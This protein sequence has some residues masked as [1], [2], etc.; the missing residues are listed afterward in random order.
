MNK[1]KLIILREYLTRIKKKSFIVMT[2]L[3]PVLFAAMMVVPAWLASMEDTDM[4]NIAVVDS[5]GIF[6]NKI[7]DTD[8][9]KFEYLE[10]KSI[11]EIHKDFSKS[12]YYAVLQ[13]LPS[14]TY[15][16][17]AVHLFSDKQTSFSVKSHIASAMEKE[18][19]NRKLRAHGIDEEILNSIKSD[20]SIRTIQWT[21]DGIK[22]SSTEV[23]MIVGYASGFLIYFFIFLFGAQVMRGVIEEKTNRIVEI[24]VSSAK[25]FQLMMGKIVGIAMV[26]LT[27]FLL[28]ILLTTA[29]ITGAKAV[30]FPD[31]GTK[32]A[33]EV[34]AQDLF[35]QQNLAQV[36]QIQPQELDKVA[37]IFN[38]V[39]SI[40]FGVIFGSFIFYF[41]GGYLLYGSLFAAIGSAVDNE[42]DT[43]QFMLPITIP[44]ILGI[45]VMMNAIQTPDSPV[46]F[47]FSIIPLTSPIVMMVRIP[48]GVPYW[49]IALSM[50]L[51]VITF[52]G[53]VWLA[54]KIYRTGILMYGKKVNYKEIWKW[55][56]YKS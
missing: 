30:F 3:G 13:I 22:E 39:K 16:P 2:I 19:K 31:L 35:Q 8:Y 14:I 25:P 24:I 11:N 26:G 52:L 27:Q 38:S 32:N 51:L 40:D 45:F 44:L 12:D 55:L 5:S 47:W 23:A 49:Q 9:I 56:R 10:N 6:I 50:G 41:L 53:S 21:E 42:T 28:W 48:F 7:P 37:Q 29:I 1:I 18:L 20:V 34:V 33:Q 43:Q 46:A 17:S 4:K 36:E 15:E 54:G